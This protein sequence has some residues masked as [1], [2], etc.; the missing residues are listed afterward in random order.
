MWWNSFDIIR[1]D[2]H[3][4][5]PRTAENALFTSVTMIRNFCNHVSFICSYFKGFIFSMGKLSSLFNILGFF[6][7]RI[8]WQQTKLVVLLSHIFTITHKVVHDSIYCCVCWTK[9]LN[10][11]ITTN[12]FRRN[13]N[14]WSKQRKSINQIRWMQ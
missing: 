3:Q 13:A 4:H 8:Y 2:Y 5:I 9:T 7:S 6:S 11:L 1:F 10:S 12:I 14:E